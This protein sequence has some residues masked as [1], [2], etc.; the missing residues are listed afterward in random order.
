[1][2]GV[3]RGDYSKMSFSF[4]ATKEDWDESYTKRSVLELQLFDA[5]VV[6]SPANKMTS[7]GIRSYYARHFGREGMLFRSAHLPMGDVHRD[8]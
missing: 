2:S 5:S 7:V 3:K 8:T 6:K 4:R 1:M